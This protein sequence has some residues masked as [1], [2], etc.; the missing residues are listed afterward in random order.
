MPS[1]RRRILCAED[2]EDTCLMLNALLA[3]SNYETK[4]A[5]TVAETLRLAQSERF[6]LYMLDNVFPDGTGVELCR[7]L[8]PFDARTPILFYS[9][10]AFES[11]RQQAIAAGAQAYLTKP[12][13]DGLVEAITNLLDDR[14]K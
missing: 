3:Q 12:G 8:R 7:K 14:D 1:P 2:N 6:D 13:I 10:A 11:D 9:G 4:S 5:S